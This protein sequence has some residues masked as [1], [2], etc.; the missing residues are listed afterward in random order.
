MKCLVVDDDKISRELICDYIADTEDL[1]LL[2]ECKSGIEASNFLT[3]NE[4]DLIF[5]DIEMPKMSGI[6]LI[7]SLENRPQFILITSENKYA[8]EAFEVEATDYLVKPVEYTRFLKALNKVRQNNKPVHLESANIENLFIKVDSELISISTK[9]VLWIEALGDYVNL[10]TTTKKYT[11]LSTMKNIEEKL[12][13]NQF[14]RVHRSYF[15]R[16]DRIK[17][18]SDDIILVENKLIPVSKS[19]KK[20]LYSRLNML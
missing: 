2:K 19:Y 7:R 8:V 3:K 9:D 16:T 1:E 14:V 4:V 5:L 15:V 11:I 6:E 12:P 18:I 17:K 10:I 13:L 20:E